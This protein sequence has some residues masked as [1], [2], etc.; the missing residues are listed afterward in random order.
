MSVSVTRSSL[1][2]SWYRGQ[3]SVFLIPS[4]SWKCSLK[5]CTFWWFLE[6]GGKPLSDPTTSHGSS[7]LFLST[8]TGQQP[9]LSYQGLWTSLITP[10]TFRV[11]TSFTRAVSSAFFRLAFLHVYGRLLPASLRKNTSS[12]T[13]S[14]VEC[15]WRPTAT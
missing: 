5:D 8:A 6:R 9:I 12:V 10:C 14:H 11:S 1:A 13:Y 15:F 3:H 4:L 7:T 2:L